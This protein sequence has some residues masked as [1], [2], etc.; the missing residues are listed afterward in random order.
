MW[1]GSRKESEYQ[2]H[3]THI[4]QLPP[5]VGAHASLTEPVFFLLNPSL[6]AVSCLA[7]GG[8]EFA[9]LTVFW[10]I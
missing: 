9:A 5:L 1:M 7:P 2:P 4:Q 8:K 10:Y 3:E 6:L